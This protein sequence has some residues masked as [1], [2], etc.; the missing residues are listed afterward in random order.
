MSIKILTDLEIIGKRFGRLIVLSKENRND[1]RRYFRCRCDCGGTKITRIDSLKKGATISCGC[2]QKECG[3]QNL[4][5]FSSTHG[6][7]LHPLYAIW[8]GMTSRCRNPKMDLTGSYFK[9]GIVVCSKWKDDFQVFYDWCISN[10]W[11]VGLDLDRKDNSGN[12]EPSNCRFVDRFISRQ[13][14][15]VKFRNNKTGYGGVSFNK[16]YG[17]YE[18]QVQINGK[19]HHKQGFKTKIEAAKWRDQQ[20]ILYKGH[21]TLNFP[22]SVV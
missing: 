8:T 12:Y 10:G 22:G 7:S 3:R 21:Q 13:N 1:G 9:K 19:N 20:I 15:R 2:R 4:N 14:R 18:A 11:E 5:K 17:K 16:N 6:L